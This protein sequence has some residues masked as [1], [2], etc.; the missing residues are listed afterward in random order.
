MKYVFIALV[1]F[2]RKFIS[3]NKPPCCRFEPSCSQYSIDA[4]TKHGAIKGLGLTV[5]RILRCNPAC[6]GG[7]DPVPPKKERK[8]KRVDIRKDILFLSD[9]VYGRK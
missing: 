1:K 3:P 7:Y 2:Y 8:R 5:W 4:F 9:K 6:K